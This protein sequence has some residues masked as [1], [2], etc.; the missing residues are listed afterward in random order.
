VNGFENLR[1]EIRSRQEES[2]RQWSEARAEQGRRI[3]ELLGLL[4]ALLKTQL[5]EYAREWIRPLIVG[6][7]VG[8]HDERWWRVRKAE[9]ET[10]PLAVEPLFAGIEAGEREPE[11]LRDLVAKFREDLAEA[12]KIGRASIPVAADAVANYVH[13]HM[14]M[15]FHP[16][17]R[18]RLVAAI[19]MHLEA[20]A[21]A[22]MPQ[23]VEAEGRLGQLYL[24]CADE[25]EAR[26]HSPKPC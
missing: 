14:R 20:L 24:D 12:E 1:A 4:P 18:Q 23:T 21:D 8:I 6:F 9:D 22:P 10:L 19:R 15:R 2:R 7:M 17:G 26:P 5:P 11:A 3:D 25:L 16:R 13:G